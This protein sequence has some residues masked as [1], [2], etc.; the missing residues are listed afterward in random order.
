MKNIQVID[1]AINSAFDIFAASDEEFAAI[2]PGGE[3]IAFIDDIQTREDNDPSL[4]DIF[5]QVYK[6]RVP[7]RDAMG[8]HGVI[9]FD[10]DRKKHYP[11]RR[12]EE[13]VGIR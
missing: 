4:V 12:D 5:T 1:G 9:F 10:V 11:T 13:A 8:I 7:K 6:R 2:F 3:D